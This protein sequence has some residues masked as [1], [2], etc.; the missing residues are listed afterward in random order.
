[1]NIDVFATDEKAEI[2][3]IWKE[4]GSGAAIKVARDGNP[5]Y[6]IMLRKETVKHSGI[7]WTEDLSEKET[8]D[9]FN[10]IRAHTILLDWRGIEEVKD[11]LVPYSSEKA[12]EWL[13]KYK[14]FRKIVISV[15]LNFDNYRAKQEK[16]VKANIKK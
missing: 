2:E 14:E 15:S 5:A 12:F 4:L 16:E 10:K 1:M 6:A 8:S 9:I 7:N 3:G 11:V 13:V